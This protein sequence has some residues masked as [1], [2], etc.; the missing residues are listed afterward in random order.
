MNNE[1]I[2]WE[3]MRGQIEAAKDINVL[4]SMADKL[5]AVRVLAKQ[6]KQSLETQNKIAEYRL[7]V[8]RKRGDWLKENINHE[9]ATK[10][11]WNAYPEG[12]RLNDS[13]MNRKEVKGVRF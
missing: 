8:E 13:G 2:K 7:R 3:E 6:S 4:N 10:K 1:L 12:T 9:G 11:G 5:E